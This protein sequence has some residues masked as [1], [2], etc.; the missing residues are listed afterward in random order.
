MD[1]KEREE[2]DEDDDEVV[3]ITMVQLFGMPD[4]AFIGKKTDNNN[5][6]EMERRRKKVR[7]TKMTEVRK[8][9]TS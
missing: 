2:D 7:V 3:D 8:G 4:E 1:E 5:K 9:A 6:K